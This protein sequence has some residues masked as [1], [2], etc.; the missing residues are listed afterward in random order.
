MSFDPARVEELVGRLDR[1]EIRVAERVDHLV[2]VHKTRSRMVAA[3]RH[4][5]SVGTSAIRK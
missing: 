2:D 3:R 5:S 4:S 1:G